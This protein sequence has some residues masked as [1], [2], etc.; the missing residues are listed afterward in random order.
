VSGALRGGI[1]AAGDGARLRAAGFSMPKPLVPV[2]G[3]PLLGHV[4]GNFL[5]AGIRAVT[6]IVN[7]DGRACAEFLCRAFPE[8]DVRCIVKTTASSL[9]S[10]FEVAADPAPGRMLISTVDAV[11][12]PDE[13][14]RFVAAAAARP[15]AATVLGVTALVAD[16]KPLWVDV[17]DGGRVTRVGG[18]TGR[19]VTAGYY[20]VP[21]RVR[22]MTRPAHLGRLR[23][24]LGWLVA[25][26]EPVYAEG[27]DAVVDVDRPEDIALAE[28]LARERRTVRAAEVNG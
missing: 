27:I 16:E 22:R 23:D 25:E 6:A 1:I 3:T 17:A 13:F 11:C 9:E 4:A 24:F 19:L 14:A 21:E 12:R 15:G 8:L 20:L 28:R 10:F 26:G 7:E 5:A 2:G 18:S